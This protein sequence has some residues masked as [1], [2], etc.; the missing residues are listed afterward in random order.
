MLDVQAGIQRNV[1]KRTAKLHRQI[2]KSQDAVLRLAGKCD[3]R[4]AA[5]TLA[6]LDRAEMSLRYVE[7]EVTSYDLE[8]GIS[9]CLA[10]IERAEEAFQFCVRM[11]S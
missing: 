9:R 4:S 8:L 10:F 2:C 5:Y 7:A 3:A 6:L 1:I 11:R